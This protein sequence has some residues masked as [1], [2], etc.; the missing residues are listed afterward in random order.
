[1]H[2]YSSKSRPGARR[3]ISVTI[4]GMSLKLYSMEGLFSSKD[5]DLGT[6]L[7]LEYMLLPDEGLILDIG[8]GV[9]VIGIYALKKNPKLR[10]FMLDINPNAVKIARLNSRINGV[11][12]RACFL[13]SNLYDKLE[14]NIRFSA[15]YSNP[16]LSA[17]WDTVEKIII[18]AARHLDKKGFLQMVFYKGENRAIKEAKRAFEQIKVVKRKKGY[19]VLVF[20]EPQSP[21][22]SRASN[23]A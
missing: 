5:I 14:P 23:D 13:V 18:G 16:P 6:K 17:G 8:T 15:I 19:T 1:M 9:G 12:E 2:Y 3:I 11:E 7:L 20:S 21:E 22:V 4:Q 10:A